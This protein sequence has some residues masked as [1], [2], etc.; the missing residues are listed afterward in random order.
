MR[1]LKRRTP[2]IR[3]PALGP[4]R[5]LPGDR[6][7]IPAKGYKQTES[8]REGH[9]S[10]MSVELGQHL[11]SGFNPAILSFLE[12]GDAAEV[13]VGEK[14]AVIEAPKAAALFGE[15]GADGG[16]DH[17]V[18]HAHNVNAGDALTDVGVNALE[19]AEDGLFPI[20]PFLFEEKLAVL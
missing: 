17:G 9:L 14:Y 15:N 8:T 16:A 10:A 11:L 7:G 13:G 20:G 6:S 2:H 18:T 5:R 12:N 1:E 19:I 3:G 4:A